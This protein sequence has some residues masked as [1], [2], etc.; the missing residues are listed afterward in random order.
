MR[1]SFVVLALAGLVSIVTPL[2]I[3]RAES[4]TPVMAGQAASQAVFGGT[5]DPGLA[6]EPP[7]EAVESLPLP[8]GP[9][10][11]VSVTRQSRF[12]WPATGPLTSYFGPGH[13]TGI[14]I[15]M[16]YDED[17]PILASAAG[18][19]SFAGGS[20][21]CSYGY[22]VIIDHEG[23]FR[24]LYAHFAEVL[25]KEG[26]EVQQGELLG[27]GGS[28]GDADGK[29]L[30]FEI[31]EDGVLVDPLRF[32]P[33]VQNS[34]YVEGKQDVGCPSEPVT[35]DAASTA[36]LDLLVRAPDE[37]IIEGVS[38][39]APDSGPAYPVPEV[40]SDGPLGIA[41]RIAPAP[42]ASGRTAYFQLEATLRHGEE[43]ET[44]ACRLDVKTMK[45]LSNSDATIARYRARFAPTPTKTPPATATLWRPSP[46]PPP[47]P[48]ATSTPR[49]AG[50]TATPRAPQPLQVPTRTT[51]R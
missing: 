9:S 43:T 20:A 27:F 25:V 26:Q 22:H 14:D 13:P 16:G 41:L 47:T 28:T 36:R 29:H 8:E 23:G 37:Y 45:T 30:H 46:T 32:L 2:A 35:L 17:S 44:I 1:S 12:A 10:I 42:A 24:T 31:Q 4:Q 7:Q 34:P 38:I 5:E 21:C 33:L 18:T 3:P 19:V 48:A 40:E 51:G 50:P 39:S 6:P 49:G 15:G 11:T